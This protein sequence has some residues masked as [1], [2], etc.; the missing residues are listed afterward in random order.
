MIRWCGDR[1]PTRAELGAIARGVREGR[2]RDGDRVGPGR[3]NPAP[4]AAERAYQKFH[5]G[6]K[7]RRIKRRNL[8]DY[9]EL[10]ALGRLRAVE[11][12]TTK[13][14]EHAIWVHPFEKPYPTLTATP[15]GRL[16]PIV[17]GGA[18]V[19]ERGIER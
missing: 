9:S 13:G 5:W 16:G 4:L 17:G 18:F 6:N 1:P 10:F 14:D 12:E 15:S 2:I 11:Y 3:A 8:P 7:P 19:T